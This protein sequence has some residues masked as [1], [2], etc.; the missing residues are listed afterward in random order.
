MSTNL[1]QQ[2]FDLLTTTGSPHSQLKQL[3]M[4]LR[5]QGVCE[6]VCVC[7]SESTQRQRKQQETTNNKQQ[8][9]KQQQ[10]NYQTHLIDILALLLQ[11][12]HNH[13]AEQEEV[14]LLLIASG[15]QLDKRPRPEQHSMEADVSIPRNID[16]GSGREHSKAHR[17]PLRRGGRAQTQAHKGT[18][19]AS[20]SFAFGRPVFKQ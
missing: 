5:S 19:A 16:A 17:A 10:Q 8:T 7:V 9:N 13:V 4:V 15:A 14:A 20:Q 1:W 3:H 12:V 11:R 6:C 2:A 18:R